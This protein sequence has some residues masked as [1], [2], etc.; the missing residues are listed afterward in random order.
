MA[1]TQTHKAK[2]SLNSRKKSYN[3]TIEQFQKYAAH[4]DHE[5]IC[6]VFTNTVNYY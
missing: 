5:K 6:R 4:D 2:L 1:L 3:N